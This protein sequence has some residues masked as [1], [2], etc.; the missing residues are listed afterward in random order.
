MK[1]KPLHY[2]Y[3]LKGMPGGFFVACGLSY[4]NQRI[5]ISHGKKYIQCKNCRKTKIFRGVK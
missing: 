1:E 5:M 4:F 3:Y 2:G